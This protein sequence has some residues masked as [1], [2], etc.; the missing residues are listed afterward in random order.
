VN[1]ITLKRIQGTEVRLTV[2][3]TDNWHADIP[4]SVT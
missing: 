2:K 1:P 4:I 3:F